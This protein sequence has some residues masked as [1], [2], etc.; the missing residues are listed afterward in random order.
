MLY[1]KLKG[2]HFYCD[3][4]SQFPTS[5]ILLLLLLLLTRKNQEANC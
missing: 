2:L 3:I 1:R 4:M 5:I